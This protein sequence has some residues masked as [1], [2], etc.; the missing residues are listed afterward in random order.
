[1][2]NTAV[3]LAR[4]AAHLGVRPELMSAMGADAGSEAIVAAWAA[5]GVGVAHVLRDPART[6]GRYRISLGP[7]GQRSF[8]YDRDRSAA[9]SFFEHAEADATLAWAARGRHPLPD[10]HH[11]LDLRR[12]G[13]RAD[14]RAR[15]GA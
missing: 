4:Q 12:G 11:A 3:Y 13:A 15:R 10:R 1:M 14:L 9:R 5:Q 7:D 2:V 6:A 8:S